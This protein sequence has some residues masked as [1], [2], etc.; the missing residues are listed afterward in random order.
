MFNPKLFFKKYRFSLDNLVKNNNSFQSK[1]N[2]SNRLVIED[3]GSISLLIIGFFI[4]ALSALMIITDVAVVANAKRSLDHATEAAAMRAVHNLDETAYYKGKHTILTS[5]WEIANGGNWADNRI[6]I[7]CEKGRKEAIDEMNSWI[8]ST[9]N[10]KT[11]QVQSVAI[12]SYECVYDAVRLKTSAIVRLP[13][14]A[15]FNDFDQ[16]KIKSSITTLNEKDK[17]LYLFGIRIH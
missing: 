8:R 4:A 13:F 7:D 6:P 3:A 11:L 12:E 17:G 14:P 5:V 15:P 10:M 1:I 9:S 16:T 2:R